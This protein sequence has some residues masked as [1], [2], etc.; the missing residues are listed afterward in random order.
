[1]KLEFRLASYY[2]TDL[3]PD[4]MALDW[5][6]WIAVKTGYR[7]GNI[8]RAAV[9]SALAIGE[10]KRRIEAWLDKRDR[11][12]A[13]SVA[14]DSDIDVPA[15]PGFA[16]RP[17]QKA[18]IAFMRARKVSLNADVPRLGKTIQTLGLVNTYGH[19]LKVLIVGPANAKTNWCREACRWLVHKGTVGYAEGDDCPN[20]DFL[21]INYELLGRH[22]EFLYS[23]DWDI[24]AFDESHYLKNGK[25][26][27]SKICYGDKKSKM[28]GL[29]GRLHTV[30]LTGTPIWKS[31]IDL[32]PVVEQGDPKGLGNKW[33]NFVYR[34]CDAKKTGFGW[35]TSGFSNLDELKFKLRA[36]FM[37][38]REKK[39][40]MHELKPTREIVRLP[41]SGLTKIL[42]EERTVVQRNLSTVFELLGQNDPTKVDEILSAFTQLAGNGSGPIAA[43]RR[44]LALTKCEMVCDFLD[45]LFLTEDKVVV[46]VY[47]RDVAFSIKERFPDASM[48]I[49]GL[50]TNQRDEQVRRFQED[51]TV[52]LFIG[53][54]DAAGTAISLSAADVNVFAELDYVPAKIDQCEERTWLVDKTRPLTH[55]KMV[56]EDSLEERIAELLELRQSVVKLSL[57]L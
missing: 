44:E 49:G 13:P 47:H 14:V 1:M 5:T 41:K 20:T 22:H 8:E 45:E 7:S 23:V 30:F 57:S 54:M 19:R 51:P 39:D 33:F 35:D 27:R 50:S 52:R 10:A 6:G 21:S 31:P 53:N 2:A 38:R 37:I 4:D 34:Y 18:G 48:V 32:W 26:A 24:V 29:S 9:H 43:I 46:W 17:Y 15:P 11:M 40:I 55:I 3:T 16:Y 28:K 42:K 36:S 56:I 12:L 25:S